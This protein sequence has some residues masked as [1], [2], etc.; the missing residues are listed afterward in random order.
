MYAQLAYFCT[1][2]SLQ[3]V[4][5]YIK[6]DLSLEWRQK[7]IIGSSIIYLISVVFISLHAFES[8]EPDVWN[9]LFWIVMV[10]SVLTVVGR[11]FQYE[12][13]YFAYH[14]H[15]VKPE[16]VATSKLIT[17]AFYSI[18]LA[19]IAYIIFSIFLG[20]Q[21]LQQSTMFMSLILGASGLGLTF[22]LTSAMSARVNGNLVLT[23][24]LSLPILLPLIIVI[25]RLTERS[26]T[27]ASF[28]EN[29]KLFIGLF[30]LNIIIIIIT[31]VLFPYLWRD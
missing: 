26:F 13:N 19:I 14:Y 7:S 18:A 24:V 17:N 31:Y 9:A 16:I 2:N 3:Q 25:V 20:N 23:S 12:A 8:V 10:F 5:A 11:S 15:T 21:I 27:S 1:V 29:G 6:R 30:L 22:T 28:F 4:V